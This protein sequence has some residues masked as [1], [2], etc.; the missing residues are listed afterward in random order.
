M[1][2]FA[3]AGGGGPAVRTVSVPMTTLD[4]GAWT[5]FRFQVPEGYAVTV[6]SIGV[7]NQYDTTYEDELA[8]LYDTGNGTVLESVNSVNAEP[9]TTYSGPRSLS[10]RVKN[11]SDFGKELAGQLTYT[12]GD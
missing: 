2:R 11:S 12:M 6:E 8:E 10:F 4:G 7:M 9:G 1:T 5:D 3:A